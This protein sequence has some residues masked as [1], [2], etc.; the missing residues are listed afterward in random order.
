MNMI[1]Q[2]NK[3]DYTLRYYEKDLNRNL[4]PVSMFNFM[5]DVASMAAE[6][7][8]FGPSYIFSH[9][10]AWFVLKYKLIILE[11]INDMEE[12]E[13]KTES[14]GTTKLFA[15]RDF[16]FYH[17][18]KVFAKASSLWAL[19]DFDSKKMVKPQEVLG[20]RIPVFE[21]R[22]DDLEYEKI[23]QVE[24][25]GQPILKKEFRI[26]F[27]DLDVNRH[28]NNANYVAWALETLDY[29]FKC[30]NAIKSMD[31]YYKKDVAYDGKIVSE[32]CIDNENLISVH[33]IKN[34][35]TQ[36][37]L[38]TLKIEWTKI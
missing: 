25:F 1:T 18:G 7:H 4:K 8:G 28:V 15:G 38:C 37:E 13:V 9:N 19:V 2:I 36:E 17:K 12:I 29:N 5:Q 34:A 10:L 14:R 3:Y 20:D 26:R 11:H 16:Y 32:A 30:E 22:E 27:D 23:P 21:K 33:S 35:Q 24:S 6:E 31:V